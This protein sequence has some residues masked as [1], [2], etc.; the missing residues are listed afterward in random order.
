MK[1]QFIRGISCSSTLKFCS[2]PDDSYEESVVS[3]S[4]EKSD[5]HLDPVSEKQYIEEHLEVSFANS[6]KREE[7]RQRVQDPRVTAFPL[8]HPNFKDC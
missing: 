5:I 4:S 6:F 3:E 1:I 7:E 2:C 8:Y